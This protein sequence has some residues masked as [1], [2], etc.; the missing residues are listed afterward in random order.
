VLEK[1]RK[2]FSQLRNIKKLILKKK[3]K[4]N[5]EKNQILNVYLIFFEIRISNLFRKKM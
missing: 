4:E 1:K 2:P 3:L 5:F